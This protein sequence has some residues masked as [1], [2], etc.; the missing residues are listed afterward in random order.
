[1]AFC[2]FIINEILEHLRTHSVFSFLNCVL[3]YV[4]HF[5]E[6]GGGV[7]MF[8]SCFSTDELEYPFGIFPLLFTLLNSHLKCKFTYCGLF[9]IAKFRRSILMTDN[10]KAEASF[11]NATEL[12]LLYKI[13][14][15]RCF[16]L[17]LKQF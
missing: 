8:C 6:G 17:G 3:C 15:V 9:R 5:V 10:I 7:P 14:L 12:A 2:F 11:I 4:F 13:S 1:M 16:T